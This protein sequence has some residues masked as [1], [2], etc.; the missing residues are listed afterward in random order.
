MIKRIIKIKNCPSFV[1]F[2]PATDL[3]DF[4]KFNLVYGW[5]G[6]G[7]T[8]LS[9]ILRSFETGRCYYNDSI[10]PEFELKLD[11]DTTIKHTNLAGFNQIRVFN[12]DFISENVSYDGCSAKPIFYLGK[13]NKETNEKI[14]DLG[15][16]LASVKEKL[17]EKRRS[18][19][20]ANENKDKELTNK[21]KDIRINLT[22]PNDSN[23]RNYERPNLET[24]LNKHSSTIL[25]GKIKYSEKEL[26]ALKKAIVQDSK[27][28]INK[29]NIPDFDLSVLANQI[30]EVLSKSVISKTLEELSR[31]TQISQWVEEGLSIH[32][33]RKLKKCS[34]CNQQIADTR[35]KELENHFND[36]YQSTLATVKSL[37]LE[38]INRKINSFI[39]PNSSEFY[40]DLSDKYVLLK[41]GAE[42]VITEFNDEL[43]R[44][45]NILDKKSQNLF[46]KQQLDQVKII[47]KTKFDEINDLIEVHN[48]RTIDFDNQ[49]KQNKESLELYYLSEFFKTYQDILANCKIIKEE[50]DSL[51][52]DFSKKS[53]ELTTLKQSLISFH[54]PV[55]QINN[56]L[57]DFLGRKDLKLKAVD[58]DKGYE[59]IRNGEVA[60]DLSEG[61]KTALAIV[62]FLAKIK[63]DSFDL[64]NGVVVIDDPVSSLDSGA[65]FQAYGFIKES[66]KEAG[67]LIVLTHHFDFFRQIKRWFS[68]SGNKSQSS[69]FMCVC[70]EVSGDRRS[71]LVKIDDLLIKYESEYHFLFSLL[72]RLT[73]NNETNLEKLYSI[74]NV[75]RKFLESFLAFRVPTIGNKGEPYL[76]S[77]LEEIEFDKKKKE[78]IQR[79]VET[80]SHPRYESGIQDFDMTVLGEASSIVKDILELVKTEDEK[81][82]NYL[83]KSITI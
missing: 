35:I 17:E 58:E 83:V 43:E 29:I 33:D 45:K 7:K 21:A 19:V 2:T 23:Y 78:R 3:P 69:F 52:D 25:K 1:D 74:P 46:D 61:E 66:V 81:H 49:I 79:F 26:G 30:K 63:E 44:I 11:N 57:E 82:Y 10:C 48:K 16:K 15:E 77:R 34:F 70:S 38:V 18:L 5:N 56:D 71:S 12:K 72:H 80:H 28:T 76:N 55:E 8:S 14:R 9:R 40:G 31:D 36:E 59:I 37:L 60:R 27:S 20:K 53:D 75:A 4:L 22:T 24:S 47:D 39:F 51:E 54:I 62:Y 68:W 50:A 41:N 65:I 32:K 67:Q 6:S 13:D 73:E 42:K 64:K